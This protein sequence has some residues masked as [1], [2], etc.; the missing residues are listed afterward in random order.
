M[1]SRIV[2]TNIDG[3]F[4]VA[5]QDNS[6]QGFRDNF[7][8]IKN[9]F[10]FARNEISDLQDNVLLK[11]ALA[12][13]ALNNDLG[14]TQLTNAQLKSWTQ[15]IVNLGAIDGDATISFESGNFQKL[16]TA[17][18]VVLTVTPFPPV[19][20][21]TYGL[22]RVWIVVTDV[23]HTI[24]LP[25]SV[26]I[27]VNNIAGY[28]PATRT[29]TFDD[30]GNY[31][32]DF[33]SIDS[34]SNF[35]IFDLTASNDSSGPAFIANV[36][37][38]QG[39]PT[40]PSTISQ[41]SL[42]YDNVSTNDGSGYN[43]S[44]GVFTAPKSGFYQVSASIGVTPSNW[45]LVSTYESAGVIGI[46]KNSN[47]IASGPYIDMRGVVLSGGTVLEVTTS[48][49]VSTGVYL[50]TGDTLNCALAYLTTAPNNFWNTSTN[51]VEGSFTACWLQS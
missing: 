14:G 50:N 4:P 19:T 40:S 30:V 26:S 44:T 13:V 34:G 37:A 29:I 32:F 18:P 17:G 2:P 1:S 42:I 51:L 15:S 23:S 39:V 22:I 21:G 31:V 3:T 33:S 20:A 27:G 45:S 43:S 47:P 49:S 11:S 25:T 35:L 24:T 46:Y 9:N 8:N 7:T 10:T 16:T 36:S 41:L 5:G 28:D 12:G 38:G 48:S 6:S